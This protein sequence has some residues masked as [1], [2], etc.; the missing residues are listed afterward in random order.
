MYS[1]CSKARVDTAMGY[2][3]FDHV[4]RQ[5]VHS[6]FAAWSVNYERTQRG[7]VIK[8]KNNNKPGKRTFSFQIEKIL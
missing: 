4:V 5:M 2:W 7:T 1:E 6:C 3:S 8:I